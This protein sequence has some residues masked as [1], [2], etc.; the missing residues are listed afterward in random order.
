[1]VMPYNEGR[2]HMVVLVG[3]GPP[4]ILGKKY[5]PN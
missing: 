3:S 1:M 5:T 2:A 4:Q